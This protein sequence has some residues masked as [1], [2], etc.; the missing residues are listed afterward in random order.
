M[1]VLGKTRTVVLAALVLTA[2]AAAARQSDAVASIQENLRSGDV[3]GALEATQSE[4][5]QHPGDARLYTLQGIALSRLG[6]DTEAL[7]AFESALNTSPDFLAA[8]EGAAGLEYKVGSERA[9]PLLERILKQRPDDPTSHAMLATY[10]YKR[11]DCPTAVKH[12]QQSNVVLASQTSGMEEYGICLMQLQRVSEAEPVFQKISMRRS[13]DAHARYNLAVVQFTA[14]K[15]PDAIETLQPLLTRTNPDPDTLD[16]ASAAFEEMG[17]TPRAVELLRHAIVEDPKRAKYYVDFAAISFKH[18]SYQVGIDMI[19]AGIHQMPTDAAL[20]ISRGILLIQQ[21]QYSAGQADFEMANR[22]DPTQAS[23]SVAEGLSLLQQSNVDEAL[24][25]VKTELKAHP[26]DAFLQYLKAEI[27]EQKGAIVGTADFEE[28]RRAAEEA[29]RLKPDFLL[30][31]NMLGNIYLKSE[32]TEK[33]M[34]QCRIVL[35]SNPKD[36]V[37]LYHLLL[38]LRKTNDPNREIPEIVNR[39]AVLREESQNQSNSGTKYKLYEPE[40]R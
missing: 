10:A 32:Q 34:E 28:A 38:A 5:K 35:L 16:L 39:L 12:F 8:L 15:Y 2:V 21:G 19:N 11:N 23:A 14:K 30:A 6:R 33:A 29:V 31:H 26:E 22:L 27:L 9:V 40:I 7:S 13:A 20:Y 24:A 4:L 17:D 37:A 25:T 36:Q 18:D 1:S 3:A